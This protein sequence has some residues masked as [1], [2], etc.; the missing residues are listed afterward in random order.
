MVS[1]FLIH[2]TI[3]APLSVTLLGTGING[4]FPCLWVD[5]RYLGHVRESGTLDKSLLNCG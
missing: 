4:L 3:K 2:R 5:L 1:A